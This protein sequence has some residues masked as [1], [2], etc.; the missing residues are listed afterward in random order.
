MKTGPDCLEN[1]YSAPMMAAFYH[2]NDINRMIINSEKSWYKYSD[3]WKK[4]SSNI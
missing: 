4:C 3:L 1:V 2:F